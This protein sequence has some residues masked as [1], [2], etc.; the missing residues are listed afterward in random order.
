MAR[1]CTPLAASQKEK[2]GELCS[3]VLFIPP[4]KPISYYFFI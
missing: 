4:H 3:P 2:A 1:R